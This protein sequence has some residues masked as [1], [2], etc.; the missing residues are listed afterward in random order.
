M[1]RVVHDFRVERGVKGGVLV[2]EAFFR[3]TQFLETDL[4]LLR[5][6]VAVHVVLDPP[7]CAGR[8][9]DRERAV[10]FDQAPVLDL[11]VL[12]L[13][14][15]GDVNRVV[16]AG[17][18]PGCRGER[19]EPEIVPDAGVHV[20]RIEPDDGLSRVAADAV[21][22]GGTGSGLESFQCQGWLLQLGQRAGEPVQGPISN[23]AGT[24]R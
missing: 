21:R 24:E 5:E 3:G 7:G 11:G 14:D 20:M 1:H 19:S 12:D 23:S 16:F 10:A 18:C 2:V 15:L 17:P 6:L 4:L 9:K 22:A 8:G 13:G